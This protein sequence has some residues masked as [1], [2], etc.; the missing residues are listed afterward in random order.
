MLGEIDARNGA[1]ELLKPDLFER[2][3]LQILTL[4]FH[5]RLADRKLPQRV[6]LLRP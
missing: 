2:A 1:D 5:H 3:P 6:V 4:R